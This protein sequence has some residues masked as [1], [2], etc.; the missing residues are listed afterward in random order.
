MRNN[1]S[2]LPGLI[3]EHACVYNL[4]LIVSRHTCMHVHVACKTSII[5]TAEL[6]LIMQSG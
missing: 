5:Y 4:R 3:A 1:E 2:T 6:I